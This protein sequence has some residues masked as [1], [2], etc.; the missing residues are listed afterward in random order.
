MINVKYNSELVKQLRN[1]SLEP[2][3]AQYF[4][5]KGKYWTDN[6][7][8][9]IQID[10]HSQRF[11]DHYKQQ[12]GFGAID[13]VQMYFGYNFQE[14]MEYLA[15]QQNI[16]LENLEI[17]NNKK[18]FLPTID[19]TN[20]QTVIDYLINRKIEIKII[21][22]LHENKLLYSDN[23]SNCWFT[24][25]SWDTK[26]NQ[27]FV[28]RGTQLTNKF[29]Y[30]KQNESNSWFF[31]GKDNEHIYIT[32]S[33]IDAISLYQILSSRTKQ[34]NGIYIASCGCKGLPEFSR[35]SVIHIA[36]DCDLAGELFAWKIA[37][38]YSNNQ[39]VRHIPL[40]GKDFNDE[41][42]N[43]YHDSNQWWKDNLGKEWSKLWMPNHDNE[44]IIT[45][46]LEKIST[47]IYDARKNTLDRKVS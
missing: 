27:G 37:K 20:W 30:I 45:K 5:P 35:Q 32:E 40:S 33:P 19:E 11:Y 14:A 34:N 23:Y 31:F 13:F 26:E 18:L 21:N 36:T 39:I 47:L 4:I 42:Q 9:F 22:E 44:S 12:G 7:G 16:N 46:N 38:K 17:L 2:I 29:H 28:L 8:S 24:L 15:K 6:L 3:L 41:L 43:N 1:S 10:D 25:R